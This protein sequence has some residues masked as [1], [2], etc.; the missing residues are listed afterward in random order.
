MYNFP[1]LDINALN[2][3]MN[4]QNIISKDK[5]KYIY[6]KIG[7]DFYDQEEAIIKKAR[8]AIVG[9]GGLP[10]SIIDNKYYLLNKEV[11][12][13]DIKKELFKTVGFSAMLSYLNP[14]NKNLND[15]SDTTLNL[16][17]NSI[18]HT[19]SF[20][21]LVVGHSI[22]VEHE[23]SS[24]RDIMHLSRLTV[25]KTTAQSSP[26]LTLLNE[27]HLP[28]Y[29]KILKETNESLKIVDEKGFKDVEAR[30][31]LFPSAKSSMILLSGTWRNF[32]KLI[33]L[34]NSGGKENEF[35]VL[36]NDLE[37]LFN[38]LY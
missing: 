26:C 10:I 30:N 17:H 21:V 12:L 27:E 24:Q 31:L 1:L 8:V 22:G 23:L 32:E 13:Q 29:K 35:I 15:I 16:G 6:K 36:L 14:K 9:I 3:E 20:N 37:K 18:K 38:W 7:G 19:V 33:D 28:V 25:A 2:N 11:S 34:K 5:L 4:I